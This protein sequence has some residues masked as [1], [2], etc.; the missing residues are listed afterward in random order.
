MGQNGIDENGAGDDIVEGKK[1]YANGCE[2][3]GVGGPLTA[4]DV[5]PLAC[6][7]AAAFS[8]LGIVASIGRRRSAR[9][10]A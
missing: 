8:L 3:Y 9:L 2:I 5:L 4:Q 6:L 1:E 10:A 7:A